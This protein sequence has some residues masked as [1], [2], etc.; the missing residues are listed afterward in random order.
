MPIQTRIIASGIPPLA[1]TNIIGDMSAALTAAG[2][3][4]TD[5]TLMSAG[6]NYFGTVTSSTGGKLPAVNV[7]DSV[8]VING[9]ASTLSVY[10]QLGE[11]ITNGSA[12]AAF[13]VAT[14]KS[15]LFTKVTD[16]LW[17]VLLS[18]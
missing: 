17:F 1:A 2:T 6:Q 15:C 18:A 13:S 12:N 14:L 11:S 7:G 3:T 16:T 9:G 5:A 8:Y 4:Q 10:G